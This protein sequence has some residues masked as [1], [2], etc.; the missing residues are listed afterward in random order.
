[1][2]HDEPFTVEPLA[3]PFALVKDGRY[4]VVVDINR[5]TRATLLTL[6]GELAEMGVSVVM[7]PVNGPPGMA[8]RVIGPV[9]P[10][11]A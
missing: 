4:L 10:D 2:T 5:V 11:P 7:V 6:T 9:E 1:M 8:V 3:T